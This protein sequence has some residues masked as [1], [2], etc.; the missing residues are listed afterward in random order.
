MLLAEAERIIGL[1]ERA[2]RHGMATEQEKA[3]PE[4]WEKCSI[5]VYRTEPEADSAVVWPKKP[6]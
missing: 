1:L 4:T 2:V 3:D 6:E 5:L